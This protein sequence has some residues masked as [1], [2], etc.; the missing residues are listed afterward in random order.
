MALRH[1]QSGRQH[2]VDSAPIHIDDFEPPAARFDFVANARNG[3]E[4]LEQVAGK[5]LIG[6]R[7]GKHD[8]ELFGKFDRRDP[9]RYQIGPIIAL[10][11]GR[12]RWAFFGVKGADDRLQNIGARYDTLKNSVLVMDKAHMHRGV[13]QDRD[14]VSRIEGL[15]DDRS[16]PN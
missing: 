13:P 1:V 15:R 6:P 4:L 12:L 5:G 2:L 10:H 14:N 9:T 16:I 7:S 11:E 3:P 8:A